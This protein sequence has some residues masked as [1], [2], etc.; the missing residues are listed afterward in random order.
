[1]AELSELLFDLSSTDRVM[2][3]REIDKERLRLSQ[4]ATRLS[5][6]VQE[7]SRHLTRLSHASLIGRNS[8]GLYFLTAYGKAILRLIPSM[9]FLSRH[10]EYFV[11]HDITSLPLSFLER[12]GELSGSIYAEKLGSVLDHTRQVMNGAKGFVWLMADHILTIYDDSQQRLL[13]RKLSVRTIIPAAESTSPQLR[14]N[15]T[16]PEN[17]EIRFVDHVRAGIAM[18]DSVAGVVFPDLSGKVDFSCGFAGT[19]HDF[20]GWCR[21][22][23]LYHWEQG[24]KLV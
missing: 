16:I 24:K 2:L 18:N 17:M 13:E 5:A 9:D 19:N 1:M 21:D 14:S 15:V 12:V 6:T 4:L 11:S 8:Q 22:L 23:F 3:L 10:R 20:Y 7:T